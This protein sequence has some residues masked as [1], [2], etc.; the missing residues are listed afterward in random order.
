MAKTINRVRL[1]TL[2]NRTVAQWLENLKSHGANLHKKRDA[3][4]NV[5]IYC[6]T[7]MHDKRNGKRK[8]RNGRPTWMRFEVLTGKRT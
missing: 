2:S 8:R 1:S 7:A 6:Q 5:H 3:I 4:L